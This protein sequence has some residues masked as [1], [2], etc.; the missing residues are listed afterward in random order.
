ML[1]HLSGS[2]CSVA[3][4][5]VRNTKVIVPRDPQWNTGVAPVPLIQA[6]SQV[7]GCLGV[8]VVGT[9]VS[10]HLHAVPPELQEPVRLIAPPGVNHPIG[11]TTFP[12]WTDIET[13][14]DFGA[15][16]F[17]AA[18]PRSAVVPVAYP[19]EI[20]T[21]GDEPEEGGSVSGPIFI[22]GLFVKLPKDLSVAGDIGCIVDPISGYVDAEA[23]PSLVPRLERAIHVPSPVR[24]PRPGQ[25]TSM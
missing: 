15:Q 23:D 13:G 7:T 12:H 5:L 16:S 18:L 4:A 24:E 3:A 11:P 17:P 10:G 2:H 14:F 9:I 19:A 20:A 21:F 6:D 1:I 25:L 8:V 22:V